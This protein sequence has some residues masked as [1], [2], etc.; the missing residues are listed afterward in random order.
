M[1]KGS[2]RTRFSVMVMTMLALPAFATAQHRGGAGVSAPAAAGR[3]APGISRAP[4]PSGHVNARPQSGMQSAARVGAPM[5]RARNGVRINHRNNNNGNFNNGNFASDGTDFQ[6]VPGLGFDY[7]H[8]AAVS[9]NRRSHNGR[10]AEGFGGGFPF[11]FSGFLLS[12]SIIGDDI[13]ADSQ[14]ADAQS[15]A[16]DDQEVADDAQPA[17]HGPRRSRSAR[18]TEPEID[19]APAP[20]REEEQY[21][22]VR[23]DGSLVFAVAYAWES[24]TLRYITPDGLRRSIGR[25]ALDIDA[26]QQ[27]NEQRG[28]NFR[29]PA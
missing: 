6:N 14:T 29:A 1:S 13:P 5:V 9:G 7:P 22:F 23:R 8:L 17:Q 12:P 3:T 28:V 16:P 27:F 11:G 18:R 25:D 26:T 15:S 2:A 10:F 4:A 24:G 21:V 19:S 20:P